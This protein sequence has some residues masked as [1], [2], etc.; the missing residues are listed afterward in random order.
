[1]VKATLGDDAIKD[2]CN[3]LVKE[4]FQNKV[5]LSTDLHVLERSLSEIL[6]AL[7]ASDTVQFFFLVLD[8]GH[9]FQPTFF[10]FDRYR[11]S[12]TF[13]IFPA[14]LISAAKTRNTGKNSSAE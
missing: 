4:S 9:E 14:F 11:I 10:L 8:V 12:V 6:R 5:Y 2:R 1:M 7:R 13:N 3:G